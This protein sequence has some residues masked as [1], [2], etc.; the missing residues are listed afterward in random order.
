VITRISAHVIPGERQGGTSQF[1]LISFF[2]T[3]LSCLIVIERAEEDGLLKPHTGSC[4]FEGTV[5]STGISIA[6]VARAKGYL[7]SIILPDD[8][9][10]QL[11]LFLP[12][13]L[14]RSPKR[15]L[16]LSKSLARLSRKVCQRCPSLISS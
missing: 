9:S 10:M 4:I 6:T 16:K 12:R 7:A 5:G 11:V 2:F 14:A 3:S 15:R 1:V 8:V 13:Y